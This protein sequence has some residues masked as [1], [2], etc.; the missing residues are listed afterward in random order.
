[1]RV[2]LMR[3][4][5]ASCPCASLSQRLLRL[6]TLGVLRTSRSR[7]AAVI[8]LY[9]VPQTRAGRCIWM[10]E[11]V[12]VPW[13]LVP[14]GTGGLADA[15]KPEYLAIN[16]N[17]R[18]PALDDEGLVLFESLAIN[19][20]L[21]R[22]YGV[23]KG[24]WPASVDDQSRAIQW[25]L[26]AANELEPHVIAYL[27][28]ARLLPETQRDSAKAKTAQDALPKPLAVLERVLAG[29][30]HILGGGFTVADLNVAAVLTL[31]WRLKAFDAAAFPNVAAWLE[32]VN[33]REAAVR[34]NAR[35]S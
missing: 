2:I 1:M 16:P 20:H 4:S 17:G 30:Q 31:G 19:L 15:K 24:L 8:K 7:R 22:K 13:E 29:K 10:L 33:A 5:F 32:R 6:R 18:V 12:G 35:R 25:S 14:I 21:A 27:L 3:G 23:V 26:W 28:N 34:A 11:E 9:G